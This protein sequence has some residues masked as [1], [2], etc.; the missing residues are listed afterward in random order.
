MD[1]PNTASLLAA[2]LAAATPYSV[3][4]VRVA[5]PTGTVAYLA[6]LTRSANRRVRA[7]GRAYRASPT[8]VLLAAYAYALAG[9]TAYRAARAR[10][11]IAAYGYPA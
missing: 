3:P 7:A 5:T 11:V 10:A 8:P 9:A 6:P 4:A 1:Y 2:A